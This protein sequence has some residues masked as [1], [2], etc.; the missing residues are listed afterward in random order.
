MEKDRKKRVALLM[1]S[2]IIFLLL[3]SVSYAFDVPAYVKVLQA[4]KPP[5]ITIHSPEQKN[6]S[7]EK[8]WLKV[9]AN[10]SV[11]NWWYKLNSGVNRSFI[12]NITIDVARC[13]N[14]L[15]VYANSSGNVGFSSIKFNAL[16]GDVD[17]DK[18]VDIFDIIKCA[19]AFGSKK[20]NS[21]FKPVCDITPPPDGDGIINIFDLTAITGNYGKKC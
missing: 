19:T 14:N 18:D 7:M 20:G 8:L 11:N 10:Q 13:G 5:V 16:R 2:V 3:V 6:Y 1:L 12:P 21:R 9:T 15:T 17:G 4:V